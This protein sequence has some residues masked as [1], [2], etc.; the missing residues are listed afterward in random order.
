VQATQ[1]NEERTAVNLL[2]RRLA[3]SVALVRGLGGSWE[4][5]AP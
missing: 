5:P 3:A 1:L 4:A 2:S